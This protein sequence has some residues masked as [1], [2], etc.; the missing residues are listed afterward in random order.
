MILLCYFIW[1]GTFAFLC[2]RSGKSNDKCNGALSRAK[3]EE[4]SFATPRGLKASRLHFESVI[5]AQDAGAD[6][7]LCDARAQGTGLGF[8]VRI[9]RFK[10]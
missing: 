8:G 4:S 6:G 1:C 10:I 7:W 3:G 2:S 9:A 5:G